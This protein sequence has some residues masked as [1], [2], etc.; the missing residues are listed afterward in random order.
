L[1][2]GHGYT[3]E[4]IGRM[5]YDKFLWHVNR[6]KEQIDAEIKAR[7]EAES[8]IKARAARKR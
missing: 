7:K 6:L 4:G 1:Y 3:E 5:D 2:H 8:K